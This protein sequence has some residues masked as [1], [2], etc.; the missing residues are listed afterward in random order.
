M[1]LRGFR[2]LADW[3]STEV[4]LTGGSTIRARA[5]IVATGVDYRRLAS[6]GVDELLGRGVTYGSA[7]GEA[8]AY[9]GRRVVIVGGG[10]SAGQAALHLGGYA[11]HVTMLVR[12]DSLATGMSRYLEERILAH[13][14][15]TVKTRTRL[16]RAVGDRRLEEVGV[17]G[18]DG[19]GDSSGGRT[20]RHRRG[21]AVDR[22]HPAV[23]AL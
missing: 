11:E 13:P 16:T 22:G 19:A 18:P 10:N 7:P 5:N 21:R 8:P 1:S 20:V 4:E 15:I 3:G 6:A 23:A 12:G 9:A 14:R 2:H 17:A